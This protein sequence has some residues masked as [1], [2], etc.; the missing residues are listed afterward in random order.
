MRT[1][2][3]RMSSAAEA[4]F[5]VELPNSRPRAVKVIALDAQSEPVVDDLAQRYWNGASFFTAADLASD[6]SRL[7][8]EIDAADLVVMVATAGS[9]PGEVAL[10]GE[11]C[12]RRRVTTT[13]L[14]VCDEET[15]DEELSETLSRLRPWMLMLVVASSR[16]Y[17]ED[18]LRALRA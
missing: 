18:M 15:S 1:E 8:E 2:S 6:A 11:A 9:D 3:A 14:I 17:I 7:R 16:D 13:G 4:R 12:S 10:I 5:R